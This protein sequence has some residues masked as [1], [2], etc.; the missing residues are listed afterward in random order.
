MKFVYTVEVYG[1]CFVIRTCPCAFCTAG[2]NLVQ[3]NVVCGA[4]L[5]ALTTD[6]GSGLGNG[7]VAGIAIGGTAGCLCCIFVSHSHAGY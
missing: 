4:A 5:A 3:A 2:E 6:E 7:V 1:F